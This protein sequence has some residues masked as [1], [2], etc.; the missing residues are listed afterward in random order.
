MERLF[1]LLINAKLAGEVL[2]TPAHVLQTYNVIHINYACAFH[3]CAIHVICEL[4][5]CV[6]FLFQ[7]LCCGWEQ[8]LQCKCTLACMVDS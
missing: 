8:E 7:F 2:C 1:Q 5:V 6:P 3:A 4:N